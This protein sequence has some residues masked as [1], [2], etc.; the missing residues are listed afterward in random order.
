MM[1]RYS[2]KTLTFLALLAAVS[3][4]WA[5]HGTLSSTLRDNWINADVEELAAAGLIPNPAQPVSELTNLQVAQLTAQA[6]EV[7]LAQAELPPPLPGDAPQPPALPPPGAE[8]PLAPPSAPELPGAPGAGLPPPAAAK[9]VSELVEEFKQELAALGVDLPQLEDRI[10]A[11]EHRNDSLAQQQ[12]EFLKR[13]GTTVSGFSRGYFYDFRGFGPNAY[14]PAADYDSMIFMDMDL[15]SIPV[16]MVLFNGDIRFWRTVGFYYA[17]PHPKYDLRWISL[18]DYNEYCTLTAGDFFQHYTP[19]TLWNNGIPV[20]TLIEPLSYYR[21]RKDVEELESLDHE[22]DWRLRGFQV[23][24]EMGWP[25][26][27]FLSTLDFQ[28]MAGPVKQATEYRFGDYYAGSHA[29]LSFFNNN[30]EV[31]GVGLLIWD[32]PDSADTPYDPND[33]LTWARQY[34]IGSLTGRLTIPLDED[35]SLGGNL[36][37]AGSEFQD[38]INDPQRESQDW[39]VLG[40]GALNIL[41]LH[42]TA[43]YYNIGPYFY[44]PGAQ[45][46]AFTPGSGGSDYLATDDFGEDED[47]IGV[48]NTYP[49]QSA[50]E[51][52][53][54][55]YDRM[56][57]NMLPYG[58]ATP[59][60]EGVVGGWNLQVGD[61]GWLNSLGSFTVQMQEIE[62][63]YVLNPTSTGVTAVDGNSTARTFSGYEAGLVVDFAKAFDLNSKTYRIAFDYKDQVTDLGGSLPAFTVN[64]LIAAA[65]FNVPVAGFDTVVLSV[66]YEQAQ[67]SGGEYMLSGEGDPPTLAQYAFID[68]DSPPSFNYTTLNL[69]KTAWAFGFLC[70]FGKTFDIRMDVFLNQ[71][72]GSV[73]ADS[74]FDRVDQIWRFTYDAH[75]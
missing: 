40:T 45:T 23:S 57:E 7:I 25:G 35:F 20:Y 16:P 59:N 58:D 29:T 36:E 65:D 14:Y 75:F 64:T 2:F 17:D 72:T 32:D 24:T 63:N 53:F 55:P 12:Q 1:K 22:P 39:A 8:N 44:S 50:G 49:I 62:P 67:A 51:P 11:L 18:S 30:L 66:A 19:L 37:C 10:Y 3:P 68:T 5:G 74:N 54:A 15:K 4:A 34:Q 27:P 26:D 43:K 73:G 60:R 71:Y 28:A 13:T 61:H 41:G 31:G 42:L 6:G 70:P 52:S 47:L 69:T 48:L 21:N 46:N 38:D 56:E 33:N 9:S